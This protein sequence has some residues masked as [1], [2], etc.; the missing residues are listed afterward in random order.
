MAQAPQCPA[1]HRGAGCRTPQGGVPQAARGVPQASPEAL[2]G[3]PSRNCCNPSPAPV[4]AQPSS[5][6]APDSSS[7]E[8]TLLAVTRGV[9]RLHKRYF[10]RGATT[11]RAFFVHDNLLVVELLEVFTTVER[12]LVERGQRDAVRH[13]RQTFKASMWTEF[14]ECIESATGR[15]VECYESVTFTAPDKLL[16]IFYLEPAADLQA[17]LDRESEEDSGSRPEGGIPESDW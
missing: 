2:R 4:E 7:G 15:R 5:E 14:I 3:R 10:G 17:R 11:G 9:I 13:T 16:E 12:T 8:A 1:A 6:V